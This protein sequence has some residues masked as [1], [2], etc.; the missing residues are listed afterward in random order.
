MVILFQQVCHRRSGSVFYVSTRSWVEKHRGAGQ[1]FCQAFVEAVD[2]VKDAKNR[3]TVQRIIAQYTQLP[4][5]IAAAQPIPVGLTPIP[6]AEGL[7]FWIDASQQFGLTK[8]GP[9]PK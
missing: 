1:E 3:E 7:S 6:Q 8:T 4:L 5:R 2:F 9:D